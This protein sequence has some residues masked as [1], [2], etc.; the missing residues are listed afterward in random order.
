MTDELVAYRKIGEEFASHQTVTHSK[1]EYVRDNITTNAAEGYFSLLK[2]G[3]NG[4]FHHLSKEHL[5]RY[6]A[7][8][9]FRYNRR[10]ITD[11]ERTVSAIAGFE[12]KR[13]MYKDS[14]S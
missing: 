4:T 6:L 14:L 1:H 2:R 9:D 3:V 13:L 8:F 11:S 12:G 5:H 7:E 10:K